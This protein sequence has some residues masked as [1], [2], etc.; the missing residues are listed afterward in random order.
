MTIILGAVRFV[1]HSPAL[2]A[3]GVKNSKRGG[4][5]EAPPDF[6]LQMKALMAFEECKIVK[7][8]ARNVIYALI[9]GNCLMRL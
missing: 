5:K 6:L 9:T 8:A 4:V 2:L 3:S 7:A 1:Q